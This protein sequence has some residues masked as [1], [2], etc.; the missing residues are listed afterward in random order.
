VSESPHADVLVVGAGASGGVVARRLAEA[1]IG[2]V[3]LEQGDWPDRASYR[4][5]EPDW[6]LTARKQWSSSPNIRQAPADYPV[7]VSESDV[8]VLNFN[9]VGGGMIMYAAQWPRLL[10][11][12]FRVRSLDGVADDW[13]VT[14]DELLPYYERTDVQIGVSGLGG[15]P[16]YPPGADPPLPPLP[17]GPAGMLLA[18]AHD[19]LGWHWW[20]DTNAILSAPYGGRHQCV[21][22]G[23]CMQ[24]CGEGAKASSDLTHW[25]QAI[26]HGARLLTGARVRRLVTDRRGLVRGAEWVDIEGHEHLQTADLVLCAANGIGTSRLL[27]ASATDTHPDGLANSSGLVGRRLMLHPLATVVGVFDDDLESWQGQKG[28]TIQSMQ[29]YESDESRGFVR[30]ARWALGGAGGP[31]TAA[32][33]NGGTWGPDHHRAF[34]ERFGHTAQWGLIGEDLPDEQ[35]RVEL[36]ADLVDSSGIASPK[37]FYRIP[38][39]TRR[40]MEWNI[41]RTEES[42]REAGAR[43]T[44]VNRYPANGHFMGTARMG[45][46]PASSVVD[47]WGIAHDVP[48]LGIV[49]GSIFVTAG[50][51]NPTSTI[52]ALALRAADHLVASRADFPRPEHPRSFAAPAVPPARGF[53]G[54]PVTITSI[55]ELPEAERARLAELAD[56]LIPGG[57]ERPAASTAGVAGPLLDRVLAAR[58]DLLPALRRALAEP[59]TDAGARLAALR[60]SDPRGAHAVELAVAGGYYLSP[61]VRERIGYPGQVARP[62]SA[63]DYPEYLADGLLE[64]VLERGYRPRGWE[65]APVSP[66]T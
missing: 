28:S 26:A 46:D 60:A 14:Y 56:A 3:C 6:E 34:D 31:L 38:E 22:R 16:A 7:D 50:A 27:L 42:L 30:G 8:G 40:I 61:D 36:S 24:G 63:L 41:A 13:P 25:P 54:V 43:T 51:A 65:A 23:T 17:V 53:A 47:P 33:A 18:R 15:N 58:P 45:T 32:L 48:N 39:N 35:N 66:M 5:A 12:D 59:F 1:G 2:V 29:F 57:A 55:S 9:G 11:S 44:E 37:V 20:P 64:R 10:P 52:C 4:G 62:A 49:D 21:Q 19:R